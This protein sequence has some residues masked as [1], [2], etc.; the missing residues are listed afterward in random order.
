MAQNSKANQLPDINTAIAS[1]NSALLGVIESYKKELHKIRTGRAS[2]GLVEGVLVDYYGSKVA[3]S[4]LAQITAP[5]ST[6]ILVQPHDSNAVIA[7]EKAIA[8]SGLGLSASRDSGVVR[9][10]VPPLTEDRRK[11]IV[12]HLGKLTEDFRVQVRNCRRDTNEVIKELEKAGI[13]AKDDAK[14]QLD[15]VQ[16]ST[17]EHIKQIEALLALKEKDLMSL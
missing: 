11:D 9:V 15:K 3:L 16:K 5:E 1:L 10:S 13:L 14:K 7:I 4:H 17:D 6:M 12:R 2:T 8:N